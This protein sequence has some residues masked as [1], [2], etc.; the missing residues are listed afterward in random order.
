MSPAE[1]D[2]YLAQQ[3]TCRLATVSHDGP[4]VSPLWFF[5]DGTALWLNSIV[6]SQRWVDCTRDPRVAVVIDDGDTFSQLR[7]V[8]I[9]GRAETVGE[10]PR[11]GD[12]NPAL[13]GAERGFHLKYRPPGTAI[14]YD[15][16]HAWLRVAP[17]K[18]T[19]WDYRKLD[20]TGRQSQ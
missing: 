13:D 12:P 7:G 10:V 9:Q 17:T 8:E 16:R 14:P 1:L 18:I 4:H 11:L 15:G 6:N 20:L 19:S 5:W 2:A 3:R